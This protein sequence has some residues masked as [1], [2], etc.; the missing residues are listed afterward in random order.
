M[1]DRE[2]QR[3]INNEKD[4]NQKLHPGSPVDDQVFNNKKKNNDLQTF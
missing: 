3:D 1:R 4:Q 2:R